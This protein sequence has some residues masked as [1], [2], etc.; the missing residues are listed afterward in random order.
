[1]LA[2]LTD[3]RFSDPDWLFERKLD[4]E[5]CLAFIRKGQVTLKSRNGNVISD[6]YPEIV[7]ALQRQRAAEDLIA[8]GEIVAFVGR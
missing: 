5:R 2:T 7:D 1:M 4:G 3:R 6:A 8:D